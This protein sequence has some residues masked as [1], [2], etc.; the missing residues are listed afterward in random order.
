MSTTVPLLGHAPPPYASK[1]SSILSPTPSQ[2]FATPP[3]YEVGS[4][5]LSLFHSSCLRLS[6]L[7]TLLACVSLACLLLLS[8]C[9]FLAHSSSLRLSRLFSLTV[10]ISVSRSL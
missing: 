3:K 2:V 4:A 8:G 1:A 5:S 7:F 10:S 6:S 9:L